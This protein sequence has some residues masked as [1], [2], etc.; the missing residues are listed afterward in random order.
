MLLAFILF[1]HNEIH[2]FF[3]TKIYFIGAILGIL[4]KEISIY[5]KNS[6]VTKYI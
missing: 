4:T 6:S 5:K 2:I 3:L 1:P